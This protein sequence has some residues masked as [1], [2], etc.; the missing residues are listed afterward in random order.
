MSLVENF[1]EL[2]SSKFKMSMIR[3]LSFFLGLQI[4]QQKGGIQIHQ[5]KYLKEILK[6]YKMD[7]CKPMK[8]PI[9]PATRLGPDP[10]RNKVEEKLYRGMIGSLIYLRQVGQTLCS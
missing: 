1:K 8:T 9:S 5:Q 3:E 7:S 4:S 6:K 2:M 10:S